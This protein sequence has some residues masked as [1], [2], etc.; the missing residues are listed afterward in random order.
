[1]A[2]AFL[3]DAIMVQAGMRVFYYALYGATEVRLRGWWT[4][5]D[6]EGVRQLSR[7][8]EAISLIAG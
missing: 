3:L 2:V 4:A 8:R 1:M 7:A 5:I 6:K